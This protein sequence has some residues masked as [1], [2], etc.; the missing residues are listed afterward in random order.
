MEENILNQFNPQN[1]TVLIIDDNP[2]NLKVVTNYLKDL[3]FRTLTARSGESGLERT[4]RGQ[5]D[6]ILLDV[7]MPTG[8]DGFETCSRLKADPLTK[9]I[10]VIFMTALTETVHK[11]RGFE[12]G[13]VD[14][15]TKPIQHEEVLARL[16]THLRNQDLTRR[17]QAKN[18]QLELSHQVAQQI[19]SILDLNKLLPE[20][21]QI[22]QAKFG[23]YF[24]GVWLVS[25]MEV[26]AGV[27]ETP[28]DISLQPVGDRVVLQAAAGRGDITGLEPGFTISMTNPTSIIVWV[29][30]T[31]ETYLANNVDRATKYLAV[32][33]LPDTRSELVLPLRI[34]QAIRGVLDIQSDQPDK[35]DTDDQ[36]VLQTLANQIAIAIRN[37][38]LYSLARQANRELTK[39]NADKDKFFSIVA[40][41][42]KGPFLPLLGNAELL[43]ETVPHLS[44]HDIQGMSNSIHRSAKRVLELLEN[45]LEWSR[46]Q[47]GRL[48][49][50]PTFLDLQQ[51]TKKTVYL[52][53]PN[54][55]N[56]SIT[57][58]NDVPTTLSV[59][60]DYQMVDTVI[61]NLIANALKFTRP[62]GQVTISAA[63]TGHYVEVKVRDTGVGIPETDIG[64]L[65][66]IEVH[67]STAGTAR[68]KGTGLG[69]ILCKELIEL[70]RG[71][72]W[73]D[74]ELGQGT[75]VTFTLP[76]VDSEKPS[77]ESGD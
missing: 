73:I 45:L 54:A 18:A 4:H 3:G 12:V 57:L 25:Q 74:S 71:Q 37:A 33:E 2:N 27:I 9:E 65:F 49:Y 43:A 13:A 29:C 6:I 23:Y 41:D 10:P 19:T 36:M 68:E 39:L 55:G 38:Q 69:L 53:T 46:I 16:T 42:L 75:T 47:M 56:K 7:M 48:E 67:H 21:V 30:Q 44:P 59:Y 60:A 77:L 62:G 8:I 28:P 24:V 31:G 20:V 26:P 72:I 76:V 35:F 66:K 58:Q 61:R 17:L 64:K 32:K 70:N 15:I 1:Y 11:V 34:G 52:L 51:L 22:I 40:H 5:P 63:K 50:T 14:Y